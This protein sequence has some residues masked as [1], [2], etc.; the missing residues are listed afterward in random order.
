MPSQQYS[1]IGRPF[2]GFLLSTF[3]ALPAL[4]R[5]EPF[6]WSVGAYAGQYYD[7]EPAGFTQG[8]ANYLDQYLVAVTG[9][10]TV[11]RSQTLPLSLEIDAMLG[12]QSGLASLT[13]VAIIPVLRW[14]SFPWNSILQTDLRLGPIGVSYTS[15]V[16]PLE[17]GPTGEGSQWLGHLLIEL[18]FSSPG[19]QSDEVFMR[20]HHRCAIY[21]TLNNYGA[22]GEDFLVFGYRYRF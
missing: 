9:S 13:E 4:A 15:D 21:D 22:N 6:D 8:K 1:T 14:S 10:K 11:W 12:Q 16:S 20:L 5:S 7:S 18:A 17:R 3:L 19:K 2:W